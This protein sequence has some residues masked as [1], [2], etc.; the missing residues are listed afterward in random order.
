MANLRVVVRGL[1]RNP[2]FVAV[3]ALSLALGIGAN[4]AMFSLLDQIILRTLPVKNPEQLVFL[5]H[6]GP[7][8]GSNSTDEGGG[9]SF[10]Y[11]MFRD[12][13]KQQTPFTGLA[14]ARNTFVSLAYKNSAS[15]GNAR[16]VSGNYFDLLGVRSAIGRLLG[17]DDDNSIGSHPVAVLS[18]NYWDS[19]FG[20]DP[21]VL[22]QTLAI[23]G[24]PM[25]IVG[26]AQKGFTS[27]RLGDPP[28]VYVPITMRAAIES[29]F[30]GFNDRQNY[31]V[32]LLA[33]RKPGVTIE[34]AAAEINVPYRAGLAQDEQLL[35]QPRADFLARFR[36][37]KILLKPGEHGRGELREEGR[38]PL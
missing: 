36:A 5:Y 21:S 23:N 12:L 6:P 30:N 11:P 26:V 37:K 34:R 3:A 19:R 7:L 9:P 16:M 27:D 25:T 22:N 24:Y 2:L 14:A 29:D 18:Y 15:H 35:R 28:D 8:M 10:S 13:Q 31:W 1:A 17:E 4:T 33:R 32:T 38:E 20:L